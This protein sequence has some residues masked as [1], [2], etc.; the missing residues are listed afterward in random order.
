MDLKT[1]GTVAQKP[2]FWLIKRAALRTL[3]LILAPTMVLLLDVP[4]ALAQSDFES[5]SGSYF[6]SGIA[7][8]RFEFEFG[9]RSKFCSGI[10][11]SIS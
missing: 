4:L 3:D 9:F 7:V 2:M 11:S 5:G 10:S 6:C 1:K 8:S